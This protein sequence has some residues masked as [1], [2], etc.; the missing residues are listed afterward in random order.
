[1]KIRGA[2][3]VTRIKNSMKIMSLNSPSRE[4]KSCGASLEFS[5]ILWNHNIRSVFTQACHLALTSAS[6]IKSTCSQHISSKCVL[7]PPSH[8]RRYL[9]TF[10]LLY[11]SDQNLW[12][13][14]I[15]S[16]AF[17]IPRPCYPPWLVHINNSYKKC[18][19]RSFSFHFTPRLRF[20][21]LP[22]S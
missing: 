22:A 10:A 5:R 12:W 6:R 15:C 11:V 17:Y 1:M 4:A 2:E 16:R 13:F 14:L 19:L 9:P 3:R 7:T 21:Y 8:L 20:D 18:E